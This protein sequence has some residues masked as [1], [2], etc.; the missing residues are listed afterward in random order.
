M[1][2]DWLRTLPKKGTRAFWDLIVQLQKTVFDSLSIVLAVTHKTTENLILPHGWHFFHVA[3]DSI[4][5]DFIPIAGD[6]HE[7]NQLRIFALFHGFPKK[8]LAYCPMCKRIF[9]NPTHKNQNLLLPKMR[10][11]LPYQKTAGSGPGKIP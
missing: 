7:W 3:G 5:F 1:N 4:R 11:P 8:S 2:R 10:G 9:F 6:I